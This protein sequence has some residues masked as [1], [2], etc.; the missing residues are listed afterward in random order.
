MQT[1]RYALASGL[2]FL[3]CIGGWFVGDV[4]WI[5]GK[6][7]GHSIRNS[8]YNGSLDCSNVRS[9]NISSS[10]NIRAIVVCRVCA[11]DAAGMGNH[12]LSYRGLLFLAE[13]FP[14]VPIFACP[15][16][17]N[18]DQVLAEFLEKPFGNHTIIFNCNFASVL[19]AQAK[20]TN[21][22]RAITWIATGNGEEDKQYIAS[23]CTHGLQG[24][25]HD[26]EQVQLPMFKHDILTETRDAILA[27]NKQVIGISSGFHLGM[28]LEH[29][30]MLTTSKPPPPVACG[31]CPA[32]TQDTNELF[33]RA[34]QAFGWKDKFNQL[35]RDWIQTNIGI[36]KLPYAIFF[37]RNLYTEHS[38]DEPMPDYV[39]KDACTQSLATAIRLLQK[40]D[41]AAAANHFNVKRLGFFSVMVNPGAGIQSFTEAE[42]ATME[43]NSQA[44]YHSDTY[45]SWVL[46]AMAEVAYLNVYSTFS[47]QVFAM[48]VHLGKL[49]NTTHWY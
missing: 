20:Y 10:T 30:F 41:M 15:S 27:L 35:A 28:A 34:Y 37:R 33:A 16:G 13:M 12:L 7:W 24:W 9:S 48:R 22:P 11:W 14:R 5:I 1:R 18:G 32:F 44:T 47:Q 17:A 38:C 3:V 49:P 36:N 2:L 21:L 43:L 42:V 45:L 31:E 8:E 29:L 40:A 6:K 19:D 46:G 39:R 25:Q 4:H 23:E 26:G